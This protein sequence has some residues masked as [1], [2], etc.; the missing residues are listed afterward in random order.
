[1]PQVSLGRSISQGGNLVRTSLFLILGLILVSSLGSI[2]ASMPTVVPVAT[3]ATTWPS[4]QPEKDTPTTGPSSRPSSQPTSQ[5]S[6]QPTSGPASRA[7]TSTTTTTASAPASE[8]T[9]KPAKPKDRYFALRGGIVHPVSGPDIR[10]VTILCKN[11]R[12]KAIGRHPN[13]PDDTEV[14][15]AEG[16][17]VYPGLI[18]ANSR[19]IVGSEPPEDTTNVFSTNMRLANAGGLTTVVTGNMAAKITFGSVEGMSLRKDL[20]VKLRY[21]KATERRRV[22]KAL[23]EVRQY[24]RD[25]EDYDRKKAER[26]ARGKGEKKSEDD[27]DGDDDLKPP[28]E[29]A[30]KGGNAKYLQLIKKEKAAITTANS[31]QELTAICE[32]A[33]EFG[34]RFVVRGASEGW[35]IP[36]RLGRAGVKAIVTPRQVPNRDDRRNQPHGG[37][38]ENAVIL[39]DHGVDIAVTAQSSGISLMGIGG[40]DL[41]N[42]PMEAAYAVRGGLSEPAAIESITLAAARVLGIDDRVGSIEVGKDADFIL[43]DGKL[44]H[45]FTTVQ[46]T[47][48]NGRVV[49][50]KSEETLFADIR[51]R[52]PTT[53]PAKYKFWPRPFKPKPPPEPG[54]GGR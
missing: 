13:L 9:T 24:L 11:G 29:S 40:Q 54:T 3:V 28:D 32:L 20:F 1:M 51:P 30:I 18:G 4:T 17:H 39:Y 31:R 53:Q 19:G 8:P 34:I 23:E 42:L 47:I 26:D 43:C 35:T 37:S 38:I 49:Y 14:L 10:G 48:V 44:L 50:T 36:G 16:M 21:G 15:D 25:K 5:P 7:T 46:Q 27:D 33:E 52:T 45:F 6:T 12:I 41:L 2:P 22:R